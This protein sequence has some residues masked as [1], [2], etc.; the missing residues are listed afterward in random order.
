M[1]TA[2]GGRES[3]LTQ[4]ITPFLIFLVLSLLLFEPPFF[5]FNSSSK[6]FQ[7]ATFVGLPLFFSALAIFVRSFGRFIEYWPAFSSFVIVSTALLLMW[8]LDEF[9]VRWLGLDLKSPPGRT[10]VKATDTIILL[11]TVVVLAKFFRVAFNSI[12]LRR[13]KLGL[14]LVIGLLGFAAMSLFAFFEAH[15]MGISNRRLLSLAPWILTF[16]FANGFF[17]EL[18][19][20]GLFLKKFEPFLGAFLSNLLTAFVFGVGHAGVTYTTDVLVF[21]AITF[22]FA[23]IWAYLMQKT[24]ALGA[25]ALFHAGADTL[26]II[27]IFSGIKT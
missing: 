9:P 12:Y 21:A 25:S 2:S 22:I 4:R 1:N 27:G 23:L 11:L 26:L 5:A 20:R 7:V 3:S 24:G 18:M 13:G 15:D 14:G 19:S 8:L 16:V 10:V 6:G 17:E